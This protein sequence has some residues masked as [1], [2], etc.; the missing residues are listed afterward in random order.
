MS[1][2]VS[3]SPRPVVL[4]TGG[5][6]RVGAAIARLLHAEG[7]DLAIHYRS[8]ALAAEHLKRELEATRPDSVLL[9]QGELGALET[10]PQLVETV[11]SRYGR[12]DGLVNNASGFYP[13]PFGEVTPA[14]WDELFASNAKGPFF[15]AQAAAPAL[16]ASR[17][18]ILNIVDLYAKHPLPRYPVYS[19]AKATLAMLTQVLALELGPEV[20]C[21]GI[22]PGA[23]LWPEDGKPYAAQQKLIDATALKRVGEPAD[24][25]RAALF[26]LRDAPFVSGQILP[27]DGGRGLTA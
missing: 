13:T 22:A 27:V 18:A 15:L 4:I 8:S 26:L 11:L 10:L 2:S 24:I 9:W 21:N 14:H 20:R 25:A 23:I 19:M 1:T 6:K 3:K 5:A 16:K 7:Y 12:L 17:G